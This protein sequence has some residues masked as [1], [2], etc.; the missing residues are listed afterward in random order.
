MVLPDRLRRLA[1]LT[2]GC[3]LGATPAYALGHAVCT[4]DAG[5]EAAPAGPARE[6]SASST[7]G[8]YS[9]PLRNIKIVRR[10]R[11]QK[12]HLSGRLPCPER[13]PV[14]RHGEKLTANRGSVML[15]P[16][17]GRIA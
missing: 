11:P 7:S 3:R 1:I 14:H 15:I 5:P 2:D 12:P 4:A 16:P 8:R 13:E 6:P 10:T 9:R 17:A